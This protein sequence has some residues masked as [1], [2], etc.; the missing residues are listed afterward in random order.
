VAK[1]WSSR[2]SVLFPNRSA[3]AIAAFVCVIAPVTVLALQINENHKFSPIDEAAHFDYVDRVGDF[4]IPRQGQPLLNSTLREIACQ[5]NALDVK[6]PPCD[7][8]H[9]RADKFPGSSQYEAQQPPPYYMAAVP[10]RWVT[11][12][13]F[14]IDNKLDATRAVNIFWFVAALLMIWAAGRLMDID[15]LALGAGILLLA[16]AP[17]VI[18][19]MS[20]V[21]NDNTG[22][23]AGGL[24]ALVAAF[25]SRHD[26]RRM[27]IALLATGFAVVFLKTTNLF[28]VAAVSALF[29]VSAIT[30]RADG[31]QWLATVRRWLRDGGA[32]LAGGIA[33]AGIWTVI[34][35]SLALIDLKTEP[36]FGVLRGGPHTPGLVLREAATIL[37]PLTGSFVSQG[38]LGQDVQV[39]L[40]TLLGFVIIGGAI[41]GLF[42]TPRRWSHTLGLIAVPTLYAG[43]VLFGFGL[44]IN[45]RIDPGLSGRYG[46][47][48][49][50]LIVLVIAANLAGRWA[51]GAVALFGFAL[52]AV[53]FAVMVW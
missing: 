44:V 14:R 49:V 19:T 47:S 4:S 30:K 53:T 46:V 21:S 7:S 50:P 15:P 31:E 1:R 29:A 34:H 26:R 28:P 12:N 43:G 51:K 17:V 18:Y 2:L 8:A 24:V 16:M 37:S 6:V 20:T 11:E 41:A 32:L 48:M 38:T 36:T 9:F 40:F 42:V 39:P 25:A 27:W 35:R 52:F 10:L 13:V 23:F 33:S 45:Y 22:I 5:G 3:L